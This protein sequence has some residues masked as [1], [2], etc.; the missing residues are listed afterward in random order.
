MNERWLWKIGEM[1]LTGKDRNIRRKTCPT[2]TLSTIN[3]TWIDL[4]S[5]P[6][7]RGERPATI[8]LGHAK[9]LPFIN[10]PCPL[11][12]VPLRSVPFRYVTLCLL[13]ALLCHWSFIIKSDLTSTWFPVRH[14]SRDSSVNTWLFTGWIFEARFTSANLL[15]ISDTCSFQLPTEARNWRLTST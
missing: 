11:R 4:G 10:I 14:G 7:L 15:F 2:A 3:P 8:Y 1:V 12:Y 5:N 13:I 6:D 9:A